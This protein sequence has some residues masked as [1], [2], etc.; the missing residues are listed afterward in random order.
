MTAANGTL[1]R[2]VKLSPDPGLSLRALAG[3]P[4]E[5]RT[6]SSTYYDTNN[7]MLARLGVTLRRRVEHGE[8]L[9]QLKLPRAGARLELERPGGPSGPPE[10]IDAVLEAVL[11]G[12]RLSPLAELRTVRRGIRMRSAASTADIVLDQVAVMRRSFT[13]AWRDLERR[14]ERAWS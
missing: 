10:R 11:R 7:R 13:G 9:W 5:P 8:S 4:L 14:G 12:R 3:E 6:F 2:E 1:E